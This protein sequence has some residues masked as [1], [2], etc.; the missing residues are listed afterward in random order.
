MGM[1]GW[2]LLTA[3]LAGVNLVRIWRRGLALAGVMLAALALI[4]WLGGIHVESGS[5]FVAGLLGGSVAVLLW[6][7]T[8]RIGSWHLL[9]LM[10]LAAAALLQLLS[11][12]AN[13]PA[14][15]GIWPWLVAI[16]LLADPT[17]RLL[18]WGL[19]AMGKPYAQSET[20]H[21]RGEVIGILERWILLIV[22]ARGAYA[23]MAFL[24]AAKALARH[25]RFEED[26]E[27]A[28]YFLLGTLASVLAATIVA[29]A[30]VLLG[31]VPP[32]GVQ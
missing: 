8:P 3:T 1:T 32:R 25:K 12:Q 10:A 9:A 26:P 2:I 4:A 20:A 28:E 15:A 27:F 11:M 16:L 19:E 13:G 23:A 7:R 14:A 29:E 24:M 31:A 21:G 22:L 5:G 18:R 6:W 30:L 17:T